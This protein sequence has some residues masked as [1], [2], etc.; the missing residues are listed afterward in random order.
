[1]L[2][3]KKS[4]ILL[5]VTIPIKKLAKKKR[6]LQS[7]QQDTNSLG[8]RSHSSHFF[9][10]KKVSRKVYKI[11]YPYYKL[12]ID[13]NLVGSQGNECHLHLEDSQMPKCVSVSGKIPGNYTFYSIVLPFGAFFCFWWSLEALIYVKGFFPW[14]SKSQLFPSASS[15]HST[16][17]C[18]YFEK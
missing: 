15:S 16:Y 8:A 18:A 1:M 5:K 13:S 2:K 6:L 7:H 3:A 12:N 10:L 4:V 9:F 14:A 17:S 11:I